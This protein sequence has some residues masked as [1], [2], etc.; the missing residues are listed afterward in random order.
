MIQNTLNLTRITFRI[1]CWVSTLLLISYWLYLFCLD[2]DICLVDYKKYYDKPD[3]TFPVLSFCM[4]P[5]L[6]DSVLSKQN[7]YVDEELYVQYLK[8]E[9]YS[10][11]LTYRRP[12]DIFLD[13]T[14]YVGKYWIQCRN[15]SQ[16]TFSVTN[17]TN[18][19]LVPSFSGFWNSNYYDCY[20]LNTPPNDAINAFSIYISN[21][22]FPNQTRN[23]FYG[24]LSFI[25]HPNQ[26]LISGET[27]K[28]GF[29]KRTANASYSMKWGIKGIERLRRRNKNTHPCNENWK[30]HDSDLIRI[31]DKKVG[32]TPPYH[33]YIDNLPVCS[34]KDQM[35]ASIFNLRFDDYGENPPCEGMEK[36]YYSFE[37]ADL[38]E[39]KWYEP[40]YFWVGIWINNQKFKEIVQIKAI[41][42]NGLVGYIG[43][44]IGL[45]LGYSILQIP[46]FITSIMKKN[47][48]CYLCPQM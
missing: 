25:H 17:K 38:D 37:E 30:D 13:P 4:K 46:D 29:P 35:L 31:H 9:Y 36:I 41:D 1:V 44:Y 2:D 40:G 3:H 14:K 10:G 21:K 27:I 6:S 20:S 18:G 26:F 15:G 24:L 11:D 5:P 47:F 16:K 42:L 22:I 28:Y 48:D 7:H 19:L 39:T 34:T 43:G 12:K 23:D 8:G 33:D 32:C 45:I